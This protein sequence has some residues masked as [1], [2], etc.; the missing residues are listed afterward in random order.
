M[1]TDVVLLA[2]CA[3]DD[4]VARIAE[5]ISRTEIEGRVNT[6]R[7]IDTDTA[8]GGKV[9]TEVVYGAAVNWG[10]GWVEHLK[11][12]IAAAEWGYPEDVVLNVRHEQ[13]PSQLWVFY[14]DGKLVQVWPI[15]PGSPGWPRQGGAA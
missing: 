1:I 3:D 5:V 13:R 14:R 9:F 12:L 11:A 6:L 15:E 10:D 8:G 7:P 2:S 4:T